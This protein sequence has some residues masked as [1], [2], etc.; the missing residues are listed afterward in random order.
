MSN[1]IAAITNNGDDELDGLLTCKTLAF[2]GARGCAGRVNEVA[3]SAQTGLEGWTQEGA[4]TQVERETDV[5]TVKLRFGA[6]DTAYTMHRIGLWV[7]VG[8]GEP[9]MVSI[10]QH[11]GKGIDIPSKAES[12]NFSYVFYAGLA[13]KNG[14][15]V[16]LVVEP[17]AE[18]AARDD[19]LASAVKAAAAALAAENAQ[20]AGENARDEAQASMEAAQEAEASVL[21]AHAALTIRRRVRIGTAT[22]VERLMPG[23]ELIIIDDSSMGHTTD[24][25][26]LLWEAQ[27]AA[28]GD[29]SDLPG[30]AVLSVVNATN[31]RKTAEGR[32]W[33][34]DTLGEFCA[35]LEDFAAAA[36]AGGYVDDAGRCTATWAQAQAWLLEGVLLAPLEAEGREYPWRKAAPKTEFDAVKERLVA[37]EAQLDQATDTINTLVHGGADNG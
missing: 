2:V 12:P 3:L 37:V 6:A 26:D 19:A 28:A 13:I 25:Q 34:T 11:N 24:Y 4:I 29:E 36:V 7:R 33:T 35:K 16:S 9:V 31:W 17:T 20:A 30:M 22:D 8:D 14:K 32:L 15:L 21:G 10:Y 27:A 1:W 18:Q 5:V 23:D